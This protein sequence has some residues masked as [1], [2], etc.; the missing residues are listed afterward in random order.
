MP[1]NIAG[2]F[3]IQSNGNDYIT[4]FIVYQEINFLADWC[5]MCDNILIRKES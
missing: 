4:L 3:F 5:Y 1:D 2:H